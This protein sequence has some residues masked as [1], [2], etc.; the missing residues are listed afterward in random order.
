MPPTGLCTGRRALGGGGAGLRRGNARRRPE[1]GSVQLV[2][3]DAGVRRYIA[4]ALYPYDPPQSVRPPPPS[5]FACVFCA[6]VL[7]EI[8][9]CDACSFRP[10]N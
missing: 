10:C 9:L 5:L 3:S 2:R 4:E 7:T 8:C 6:A 1:C